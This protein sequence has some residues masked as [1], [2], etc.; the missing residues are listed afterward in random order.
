LT[1]SVLELGALETVPEVSATDVKFIFAPLVAKPVI[2]P[3][4]VRL[5]EF[6]TVPLSV[7]PLTVPVPLTLVTVPVV[8]CVFSSR[9]TELVFTHLAILSLVR[10]VVAGLF[11]AGIGRFSGL[12]VDFGCG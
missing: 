9:G 1:I 10:L 6:E 4:R 2:E 8:F 11:V 5:P 7:K 3:P 12:S